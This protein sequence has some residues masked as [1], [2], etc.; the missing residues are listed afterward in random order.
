MQGRL[1]TT[2][3]F[4]ASAVMLLRFKKVIPKAAKKAD[5]AIINVTANETWA[6]LKILIPYERYRHPNGLGELREQ[7]EAKNPRVVIP[8]HQQ[9]NG[10]LK[11]IAFFTG[12]T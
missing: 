1:F 8:L 5:K 3:H 7:I 4:G 9:K 10:K 12:E 6:E 11:Y 2:A